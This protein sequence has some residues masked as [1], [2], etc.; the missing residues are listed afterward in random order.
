MTT[1]AAA[2]LADLVAWLDDVTRA[3]RKFSGASAPV[4]RD[5]MRAQAARTEGR[6]L[7]ARMALAQPEARAEDTGLSPDAARFR[8]HMST[9]RAVPAADL[10]RILGTTPAADSCEYCPA[11]GHG[12]A[13]CRG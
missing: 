7:L 12:C 9:M 13:V 4:M 8:S 1:P 5:W 10:A 11:G 3:L 2:E 6:A